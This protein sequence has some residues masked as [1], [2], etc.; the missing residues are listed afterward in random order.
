MAQCG[1]FVPAAYASFRLC[2][3]VFV[4]IGSDDD[5]ETNCSTF[6]LEVKNGLFL[7]ENGA[8]KKSVT[9]LVRLVNK[10]LYFAAASLAQGDLSTEIYFFVRTLF[11]VFH[12]I[13]TIPASCSMVKQTLA[14]L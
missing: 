5:I 7:K 2:K 11:C 13:S 9:K 6:K 10:S 8:L 12:F 4:R 14:S 3:Q 1:S